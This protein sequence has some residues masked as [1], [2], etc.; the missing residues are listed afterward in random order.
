MV[1]VDM[2][3]IRSRGRPDI[4]M[5]KSLRGLYVRYRSFPDR[6]V[7]WTIN[8]AKGQVLKPLEKENVSTYMRK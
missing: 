1:S 8:G 3:S 5:R 6:F 2:T 7:L 4:E